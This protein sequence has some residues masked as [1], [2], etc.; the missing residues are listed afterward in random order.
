MEPENSEGNVEYKLKLLNK[1]EKRLDQLASQLL[2]RMEEGSGQEC[3]YRLGVYDDGKIE[4]ITESEYKET[5]NMLEIICKKNS[6]NISTIFSTPVLNSDKKIYEILIREHNETKYID[7]KIAVAGNVDAGKSSLLGVLT[8][9]KNDDGRGSARTSIFNF[10]HEL[11]SG[12]TS[13]IAHHILGFNSKGEIANYSKLGKMTWPEIVRNSDKVVSFIDLAGHEKYLKTTILGISSFFPD[14]CMIIIGANTGMNHM[15]KEHIFLCL[16]LKIPYVIV[17]TKMDIVKERKN[18]YEKTVQDIKNLHKLPGVRKTIFKIK[19]KEDIF[20]C[21]EKIHTKEIIPIFNISNTTGEGIENLK[22]FFNIFQKAKIIE[23]ENEE[24]EYS[25]DSVYTVPG[26]GT[27]VGGNLNSGTIKIGEV[28]LLGPNQFGEYKNVVIKSIQCKRVSLK[29]ISQKS[30]I[31]LAI[32]PVETEG[33]GNVF[34]SQIKRGNVII[35]PGL[36]KSVK[37]FEAELRVLK[38]NTSTIKIGYESTIYTSSIR[39][40]A[41]LKEIISKTSQRGEE[42]NEILR[43]GDRGIVKFEFKYQPEYLKENSVIFINQGTTRA[44]GYVKKI[45]CL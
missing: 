18:I 4:G 8:T 45:Y 10:Q 30:Y 36:K 37:V 21:A 5:I 32:K 12:R 34:R 24:I 29:E 38:T 40:S 19:E 44:F 31:C 3:I 35:S 13:S 27:V 43:T 14:L 1:D 41:T 22:T 7:I 28:L 2:F 26:I 33:K 23:K 15:T 17:I 16:T 9:G 39:Q 42:N 6:F 25:I 20:F 11:K